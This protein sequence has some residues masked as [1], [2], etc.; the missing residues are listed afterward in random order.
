MKQLLL[1][2]PVISV[3]LSAAK[4][5]ITKV[6]SLCPAWLKTPISLL[7]GG[8]HP[9]PTVAGASPIPQ[10]PG[11]PHAALLPVAAPRPRPFAGLCTAALG[12]AALSRSSSI[13]R[14]ERG[15][16]PPLPQRRMQI[17]PLIFYANSK[18]SV[19]TP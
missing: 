19:L 9:H 13:R 5:T 2:I 4:Y 6:N 11:A 7:H 8:P 12:A 14:E 1:S 16:E 17:T 3:T 10:D 18:N 15:Q